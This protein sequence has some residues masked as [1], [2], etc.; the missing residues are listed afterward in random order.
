MSES[1]G[2]LNIYLLVL[3]G[4]AG[5]RIEKL[6]LFSFFDFANAIHSIGCL[7]ASDLLPVAPAP[8]RP[9]HP[10]DPINSIPSVVKSIDSLSFSGLQIRMQQSTLLSSYPMKQSTHTYTHQAIHQGRVDK[11]ASREEFDFG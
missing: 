4:G 10:N 8:M 6:L 9:I 3:S 7:I 2:L 1:V 5:L 11:I